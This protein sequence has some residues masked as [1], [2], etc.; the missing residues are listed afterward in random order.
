MEERNMAEKDPREYRGGAHEPADAKGGT[1]TWADTEGV[2][3]R[4]MVDDPGAPPPERADDDQALS[5]A[6][7]GAVTDKDPTDDAI[8]HASGDEADATTI[9]GAGA[10]V[11][12]L[13][14]GKPVSRVDQQQLA[15]ESDEVA[16]H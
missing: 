5:D 3:P 14:E 7:L 16:S 10:D 13:E 4:E 2:V 11:E 8:D 1:D 15:S 12:D 6:A 9:G